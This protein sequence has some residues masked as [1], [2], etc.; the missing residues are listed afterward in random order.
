MYDDDYINGFIERRSGGRYEGNITISGVSL[1]P[2]E[3]T[4]FK[5]NGKNYLWLKRKPVMEYDWN[6]QEYRLRKA[7]PYWEAY[8]EKQVTSNEQLVAYKG[9]FIFMRFKYSICGVWD[10]V[11][12]KSERHRLN[13]YIERLPLNKQTILLNINE[14]N[15]NDGKK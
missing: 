7:Q 4:Y 3:A 5:D 14:R 8:L 15:R 10:T 12:G 2:I 1:S 9:E 13:L 6:T 11:L